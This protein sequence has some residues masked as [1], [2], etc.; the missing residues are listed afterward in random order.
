[1][2]LAAA[3]AAGPGGVESRTGATIFVSACQPPVMMMTNDQL[4]HYIDAIS[5]VPS[6]Q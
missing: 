2:N 1:M 3:A 4:P 6:A 5:I